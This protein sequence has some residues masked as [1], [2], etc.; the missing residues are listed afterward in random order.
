[1]TTAKHPSPASQAAAILASLSRRNPTAAQREASKRNG[2]MGGPHGIKG[3]RP[4]K[5]ATTEPEDNETDINF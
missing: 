5:P 4:R 3:G 2:A 1:M